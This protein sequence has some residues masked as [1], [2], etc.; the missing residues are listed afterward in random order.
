MRILNTPA[1]AVN[2]LHAHVQRGRLSVD[3]RQVHGGDGFI[4]WPG[5]A[6]DARQFVGELLQK[7]QAAACLVEA[8]NVSQWTWVDDERVAVYGGL[9][10]AIAEIAALYYGNPSHELDVFAVTGTNGKTSTS[11]WLAQALT[12]LGRRCG[13]IGTLGTGTLDQLEP[14]VLTTPDPVRLHEVMRSLVERQVGACAIEASSIGLAEHRFDYTRVKVALLTN[15]TQDHLDYHQSMQAYWEAKR[16]LFDWP[17]LQAAVIN[18]DDPLGREL[19]QALVASAGIGQVLTYSRDAHKQAYLKAVDIEHTVSGTAFTLQENVSQ[20]SECV[21]VHVALVGD[22]NVSNLLGIAGALRVSGYGLADIARA[23]GSL[24]SVPGRMQSVFAL[25]A[26]GPRVVVDYAHTPDALLNA[27]HALEPLARSRQ[28]RLWCVFGC[29]GNRDATKRPLMGQVAQQVA[30]YVVVTSDNPRNEDPETIIGQIV[31]GMDLKQPVH[32][33]VHRRAALAW[34]ISHAAKEDVI[35][36]A[37]KGHESYQEVKGVRYPFSDIEFAMEQLSQIGQKGLESAQKVDAPMLTLQQAESLLQSQGIAA[38]VVG[39]PQVAFS[40]VHTDT[41]SLQ[42]GDLFV[43]LRGERFDAHDFLPQAGAQGAVAVMAERGIEAA[44]CAGLEVPDT[45]KALG[46]LAAGWRRCCSLSVIAVTGSNGKTTTTQMIASILKA[47]QGDNALATQGN[48]NNAIGVPLMVLRLRAHHRV[49]VFEL[50]MNHPGEIAGLA[51]IADAAVALVN[52]AQREH[53]E[54]MSSV[55]MVAQENGQVIAALPLD[56]VAVFPAGDVYSPVWQDMAQGRRTVTFALDDERVSADFTAKAQWQTQ[57]WV[58]Q[59]STPVGGMRCQLHC[60]GLH[61]VKNAL[62][63]VACA[64]QVGVPLE[65]IVQG[66][67]A[68]RPVNGRS[69]VDVFDLDGHQVTVVNDAYNANPD[70]V[71]AAIDVLAGLPQPALLVLGDMGEVGSQGEQFHQEAGEYAR[72]KGIS[73]VWG[74]GDLVEYTIRAFGKG[75]RHFD[76]VPALVASL[77]QEGLP[78]ASI[79]VKGSRFM[80]MERVVEALAKRAVKLGSAQGEGHVA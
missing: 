16:R 48:L 23:F 64:V 30:D 33:D 56:G 40:R 52:N 18:V 71:R 24:V 20:G 14:S 70:S 2:W 61:N 11:W 47:W 41:R 38:R 80:Q 6:V 44:G 46:A 36:V 73:A 50:G 66:L 39:D 25:S 8:Q 45:L 9:K 21:R 35:L 32:V 37:G 13:V 78:Y 5:A 63:A 53:L 68:F 76:D 26:Q 72:E 59:I 1:E 42:A 27:L 79:L 34:A 10:T 7:Q 69:Q 51:K 43:A 74:A 67:N 60:A 49:A 62:A 57:A 31:K 29:G 12:F 17:G 77:L 19:A 28:G 15:V 75:A 55:E 54:F 22:Y 58:L 4:A 65:K 3:S